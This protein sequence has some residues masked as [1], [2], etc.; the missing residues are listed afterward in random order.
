MRKITGLL[1]IVLSALAVVCCDIKNTDV[2]KDS[3][4]V[5]YQGAVELSD[6]KFGL[7][8]G[9]KLNDGVGVYYI[10]LSDAMCYR[11]GYGNPYMDSEGDMLVLEFDG[12][13]AEDESNPRLPSGTYTV[14]VPQTGECRINPEKS[15]IQKFEN[16][17]QSRYSLKSG[18]IVVAPSVS[19]GYDVYTKDFVIA[20]GD[21]E[22]QVNYSYEGDILLEDYK[23]V[24]PSQVGLKEDVIDIPYVKAEGGYYGNLYGYGTANYMI[25]LSTKG[26]SDD[27]SNTL[28]GMMLVLNL[29]DELKSKGEAIAV[30]PGT[31][32]VQ[33]FMN[34]AE[35]TMLYGLSMSDATSGV[36][37][38]FG[39]FFYQITSDRKESVEFIDS[40]SITLDRDEDED[41]NGDYR[42]IIEY[43]FKSSAAGRS[44]KG[45]WIGEIPIEDM[46]TDSERLV[47]SNLT[48]DVECDMSKVEGSIRKIET[49]HSTPNTADNP[50]FDLKSVWQVELQPR[51][52]TKE[53]KDQYD[54][55]DDRLAHWTPDGDCMVLEFILPLESKGEI[56]PSPEQEYTYT[57]QPN[58]DI[59]STDYLMCVSQMGRPYDDLFH[60]VSA[61]NQNYPTAFSSWFPKE[62]DYCNT[63][64]GFTWDGW[65]SGVWYYHLEKGKYFQMDLQ[66]PA[67]KGTIKVFRKGNI[68]KFTWE[69]WDDAI[70]PNKITGTWEGKLKR[71]LSVN[72]GFEQN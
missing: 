36:T 55:W 66:A 26:F 52:W 9:D 8:Y 23:L 12:E 61:A 40:G 11:N 5:L 15:Y 41:G 2:P 39:T 53:E 45:T 68:Y 46:S 22:L 35:G 33:T 13:I 56:A 34:A 19:G 44:Y 59:E 16:N 54:N 20:K 25:T 30:T 38:P 64:R 57:V 50:R 70:A 71:D 3:P 60:P 72:S 10:V 49:L 58:C 4:V 17:L 43:D 14:G 21:K 62:F 67:V 29:F 65:F 47:L 51:D 1:T 24:A 18:S 32:K 42:Y 6:K 48:D 69:L 7:Y 63:R 27:D 37:S 28:P 31:Y